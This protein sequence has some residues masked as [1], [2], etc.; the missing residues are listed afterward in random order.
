MTKDESEILKIRGTII[1]QWLVTIFASLVTSL[2]VGYFTFQ[3]SVQP[4]Y[5]QISATQTAQAQITSVPITT[6]AYQ[7]IATV[8]P[9]I[10]MP[11]N[12]NNTNS[13]QSAT[14][15]DNIVALL[16]KYY[17]LLIICLIIAF[18]NKQQRLILGEQLSTILS[19]PAIFT[20]D[21][22]KSIV[23]YP[24]MFLE[25]VAKVL[26]TI[27]SSNFSQ[28]IKSGLFNFIKLKVHS[29]FSIFWGYTIRLL[30]FLCFFSGTA[31]AITSSLESMSI[32][33][34]IPRWLT[35]YDLAITFGS[36]FA[37]CFGMWVLAEPSAIISTNFRNNR[38]WK[39]MI[40]LLTISMLAFSLFIFLVLGFARIYHSGVFPLS[41]EKLISQIISIAFS[42]IIPANLMFASLLLI[43]DALAGFLIVATS[44][45]WISTYII[46]F[47]FVT[48]VSVVL[49]I[50]D[51]VLR[52]LV[53]YIY[54]TSF[55]LIT[56]IDTILTIL[57][58]PFKKT[59]T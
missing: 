15:G 36:F 54:I 29:Q 44:L 32:I 42:S 34:N 21:D 59:A 52:V 28:L 8:P 10:L 24:R 14:F 57:T 4:I 30:L 19:K 40:K 18:G 38:A 58:V 20:K 27:S 17:I 33:S 37:M 46:E 5:V 49:F 39:I 56:P 41:S 23:L 3:A 16:K 25:Q 45:I 47:A 6:T 35:Y 43:V 48:V 9:A 22:S 13:P 11:V 51:I 12:T 55:L 7:Q 26:T 2:I 1:P 31:I 53:M 50:F